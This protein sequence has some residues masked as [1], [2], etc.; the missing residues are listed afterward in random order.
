[1]SPQQAVRHDYEKSKAQKRP[2]LHKSG[3]SEVVKDS[4]KPLKFPIQNSN[5]ENCIQPAPLVGFRLSASRYNLRIAPSS[6]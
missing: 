1:R 3:R 6:S 4:Q 5:L 2:L